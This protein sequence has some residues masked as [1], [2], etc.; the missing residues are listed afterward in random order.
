MIRRFYVRLTVEDQP[1]TLADITRI[2]GTYGISVASIHQEEGA[3]AQGQ[4]PVIMILHSCPEHLVRKAVAE[5][6]KLKAASGP[7]T[8]IPILD[9]H[10]EFN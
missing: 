2:V 8:L 5:I 4:V 10:S 6:A 7:S 9:E 3:N 1:G